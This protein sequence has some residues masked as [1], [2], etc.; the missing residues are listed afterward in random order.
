[1]GEKCFVWVRRDTRRVGGFLAGWLYCRFGVGED[2]RVLRL[3]GRRVY[4]VVG[5]V[6]I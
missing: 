2:F 6:L 4:R 1:M 5:K 3:A